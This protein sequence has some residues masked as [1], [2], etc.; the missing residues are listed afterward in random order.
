MPK[1]NP[2]FAGL[3]AVAVVLGA[4]TSLP[5]YGSAQAGPR[6]G[7]K[8]A[9]NRAARQTIKPTFNKAAGRGRH[10]PAFN[11]AAKPSIKAGFNKAASQGRLR[12]VFNKAA[13][14]S[15]KP[16]FNKAAGKGRVSAAFNKAA[17][18]NGANHHRFNPP[19]PTF[20]PPGI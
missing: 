17:K 1:F 13:K 3:A 15:A 5:Q 18:G 7:F 16:A 4:E 12:P 10:S 19:G 11:K 6:G 2:I 8:S 14:N 20:K 9:F